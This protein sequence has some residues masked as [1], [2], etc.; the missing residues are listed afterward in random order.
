[1]PHAARRVDD[2]DAHELIGDPFGI[3][4]E[5]GRVDAAHADG[6]PCFIRQR[7]A[8]YAVFFMARPPCNKD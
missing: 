1:M 3:A 5:R 2:L 8:V 6:F 4:F 7:P